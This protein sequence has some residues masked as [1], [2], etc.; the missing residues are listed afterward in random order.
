MEG[1]K[2]HVSSGLIDYA[3]LALLSS[4][5]F[6]LQ[7]QFK[8][9]S[10]LG[11]LAQTIALLK[12]GHGKSPRHTPSFGTILLNTLFFPVWV[13]VS[14]FIRSFMCEKMKMVPGSQFL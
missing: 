11:I 5:F 2:A 10:H 3:F 7:S 12:L 6:S 8:L 14:P 9:S 1:I 13:R 4:S